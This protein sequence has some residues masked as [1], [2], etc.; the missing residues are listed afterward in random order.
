MTGVT[1]PRTIRAMPL[2]RSARIGF[3]L[4]GIADEPFWPTRN[5]SASSRTSVRCPCLISSAMASHTVAVTA[6]ALIH[7][8]MPSL[9]TTWVD[10]S[11]GRSPSSAM[12]L[13]SMAG[14]MLEYV[15]TGPDSLPTATASRARASRSRLRAMA[16][17][18]SATRCPHTSGSAWMPC[19]RPTRSVPRCAR[20]C[21]RSTATSRVAPATSRSV[22]SAS[23]SASA[24][25]SRSED[26]I[27]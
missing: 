12:T 13:A 3:L 21:S 16:N 7:S 20:A 8:A 1:Y 22:A 24:V 17:A 19:V 14:S 26:V 2:I 9:N 4:C 10:T 11:A 18:K 5:G 27:P 23:C 25:S 15:P 6:R